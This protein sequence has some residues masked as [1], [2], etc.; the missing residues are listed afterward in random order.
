MDRD[1]LMDH[2]GRGL[3]RLPLGRSR[4]TGALAV[5][6]VLGLMAVD[7][8]AAT[9]PDL[10]TVT[11]Q[12][13]PAAQ[14]QRA[15]AIR[16]GMSVLLARITGRREAGAYPELADLVAGAERQLTSYAVLDSEQIRVGFNATAVN[17]YL[18]ARSWPIWGAERPLTALWVAIDLGSGQRILLS[19]GEDGDELPAQ[20]QEFIDSVEEEVLRAADERGLPLVQPLLD[21]TDFEAISYAAVWGGFDVLIERASAR[22][23]ADAALVARVAINEFGLDVRWTWIQG[24]RS[25]ALQSS[26]L[27]EG[28]DWIADQYATEYSA[29]GGARTTRV[30]VV[31]VDDFDTYGRVMS[32]LETLSILQTIDVVEFAEGVL[33]LRVSL[34]GDDTV[35][36]RVL[37]LGGVLEPAV[38]LTGPTATF[39]RGPDFPRP[40]GVFGAGPGLGTVPG[41]DAQSAFG[42]PLV[43]RVVERSRLPR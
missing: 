30:A 36:E 41:P 4:R 34:R 13:D 7:A 20:V 1:G 16:E 12:A 29:I 22:Y 24:G 35:L 9:F 10:Y 27:R 31:D 40:D 21:D 26:S 18:T 38:A 8:L 25:R 39:E 32:Y 17:D 19:A 3:S 11:V 15:A 5:A 23:R 42:A 28:V 14:N 2:G 33:T 43:L 6:I 37:T